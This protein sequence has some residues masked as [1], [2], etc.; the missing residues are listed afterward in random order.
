MHETAMLDTEL[1][2]I[3][4]IREVLVLQRRLRDGGCAGRVCLRCVRHH[5]DAVATAM[6]HGRPIDFLLPAFPTKSPNPAKVLGPLPDLA[7]ELALRF[8]ESLCERIAEVYPPGARIRVCSDG[9][10]F[11]DLIG[12]GDD[13]VTRYVHELNR[14]IARIGAVHLS[15]FTLDDVYPGADHARMRAELTAG[16]GPHTDALRAEVRRGGDLVHMYRGITRFM[17]EDLSVPGHTGSR[18]ALQRRSRELAY[19]VIARSRAWDEL[20]AELFPDAVRLSIHPQ[21]CS[22]RK[23]GLLL[24]DT[25]DVWLTPWH[26]AAVDT[27]DGR[28]TLMK[29]AEAEAAGARLVTV[30]GRPSHLVLARPRTAAP[31]PAPATGVLRHAR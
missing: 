9:R 12:V 11:N 3:E 17:L 22:T 1:A 7:E 6:A 30:R 27:G 31:V 20:L 21:P 26:S 4:V 19:G 24:A 14:M 25:P 28:F 18:S 23:I 13:N 8:L 16:R 10:V 15:Q 29:R 5:R 2:A